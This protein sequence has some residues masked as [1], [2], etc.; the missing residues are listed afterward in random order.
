MQVILD[1]SRT[2]VFIVIVPYRYGYGGRTAN[3]SRA[4]RKTE[5]VLVGAW[6]ALALELWSTHAQAVNFDFSFTGNYESPGTVT[7]E[8]LGLQP[9]GSSQAT[10]VIIDTSTIHLPVSLPYN[11]F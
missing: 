4:M 11:F 7:G 10:G 8:I 1:V 5:R 6:L 3:P 2:L 9:N